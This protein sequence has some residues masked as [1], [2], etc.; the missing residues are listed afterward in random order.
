LASIGVQTP[1]VDAAVTD[2]VD[3]AIV[4]HVPNTELREAAVDEAPV[5]GGRAQYVDRADVPEQAPAQSPVEVTDEIRGRFVEEEA[6]PLDPNY[7]WMN[8][9]VSKVMAGK[10]LEDWVL[11]RVPGSWFDA[12]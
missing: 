12:P 4:T 7:R 5:P 6:V 2:A 11:H 10:P 9:P 3:E 1:G 8:D